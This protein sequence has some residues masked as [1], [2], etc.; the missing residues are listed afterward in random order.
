MSKT[1]KH[2]LLGKARTAP[3]PWRNNAN[4]SGQYGIDWDHEERLGVVPDNQLAVLLGVTQQTVQIA[5][6]KRGIPPPPADKSGFSRMAK[7]GPLPSAPVISWWLVANE[8]KRLQ[9]APMPPRMKRKGRFLGR[10][11]TE[12][13]RAKMRAAHAA[14]RARL[15]AALEPKPEVWP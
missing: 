6:A 4:G 15:L 11:H 12:E 13:A 2:P 10:T 3:M 5:R 9:L 7:Y 8:L 14:R 1:S